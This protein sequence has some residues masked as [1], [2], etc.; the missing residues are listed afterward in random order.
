MAEGFVCPICGFWDYE[1]VIA[2]ASTGETRKTA[3]NKCS[4]CSAVFQDPK[5]FTAKREG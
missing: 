4:K 2:T 5:L 3:L 1:P